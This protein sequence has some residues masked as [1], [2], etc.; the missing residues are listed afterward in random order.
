M[1]IKGAHAHNIREILL[2]VAVLYD[3]GS[4]EGNFICF[5]FLYGATVLAYV[6]AC[7]D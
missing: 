5:A 2:S 4:L 6:C 1:L 7:S 3:T